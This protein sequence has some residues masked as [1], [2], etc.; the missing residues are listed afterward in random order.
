MKFNIYIGLFFSILFANGSYEIFNMPSDAIAL[1]LNNSASVYENKFLCTNPA[2][3]STKTNSKS[4]SYILLPASIHYISYKNTKQISMGTIASKISY[5]N[6]GILLDSKTNEESLAY[7]ILLEYAYKRELFNIISLGLS[8]G[9][10]YSS[11]EDYKSNVLFANIGLR[12]RLLN[13]KLGL[14]ISF[15]NL[16]FATN[17]YTNRKEIIPSLVRF[18]VYYDLK[19]IPS[20]LNI[21]YIYNYKNSFSDYLIIGSEF[22]LDNNI[23]IRL[24][25]NSLRKDLLIQDFSSDI[26]SGLSGGIGLRKFDRYYDIGFKNLGPAGLILGFSISKKLN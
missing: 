2:S 22:K 11:I 16:G 3:L 10:L 1:S 12:T 26:I 14:G 20:I 23:Y 6:Y 17:M 8:G 15:E 7:D 13:K 5:I 18:G 4:Y 25:I 24:A 19:Y 9:L 21:N